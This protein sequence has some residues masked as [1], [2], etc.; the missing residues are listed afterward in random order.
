MNKIFICNK[1]FRLFIGLLL[2]LNFNIALAGNAIELLELP[3][4]KSDLA[5]KSVLM[6]VVLFNDSVL[7]VGE[8]GHIVTWTNKNDWQQHQVPVSVSITA[9]TVLSD[10]S[11]IAVGH[12]G[13]ILKSA[14]NSQEWQVVFTGFDLIKLKLNFLQQQHEQLQNT[15]LNVADEDER[16]ELEYQLEEITYNI[17]D[18]QEGALLGPNQ[19]LLSVTHTS[20]DVVFAVGAYGTLLSSSD[21]GITWQLIHN[22]LDNPDAFHLNFIISTDKDKLYIVG[23]NG[24]GFYSFDAGKTWSSM[25]MPYSGS[26]FGIIAKNNQLVAYGLQGNLMVSLDGGK[27]WHHK[28]VSTSA[29]LLGGAFS[30]KGKVFIV[31]HGGLILDFDVKNI[32]DIHFS[33]HPSGAAFSSVLVKDGALILAGQFGIDTW[34]LNKN[35]Q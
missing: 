9:V 15:L 34:P 2:G 17:E 5:T 1:V 4:M 10:G 8:R 25:T 23:E 24:L 3:A 28:R 22:R 33:K 21:K 31:G 35:N 12:D 6:E 29:S 13:V 14:A 16:E 11:K 20:K 30:E 19:P 7:A 32:N 18:T 27:Q 26:L